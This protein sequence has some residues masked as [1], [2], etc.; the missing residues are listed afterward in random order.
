VSV[1]FDFVFFKRSIDR[2][3][4]FPFFPRILCSHPW[5]NYNAPVFKTIQERNQFCSSPGSG[6]GEQGRKD[7]ESY[8]IDR[9]QCYYCTAGPYATGASLT[10]HYAEN[11]VISFIT[12]FPGWR[13]AGPQ[14]P[15]SINCEYIRRKSDMRPMSVIGSSKDAPSLQKPT[16]LT[17]ASCKVSCL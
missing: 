11:H 12:N 6:C 17:C 14:R 16:I 8:S 5:N 15:P 3:S 4:A 1:S 2:M 13:E 10:A 7:I 9:M